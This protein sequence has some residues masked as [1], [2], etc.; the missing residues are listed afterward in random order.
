MR[1]WT[2]R[3]S[4]IGRREVKEQHSHLDFAIAV[5]L[6][7]EALIE[8]GFAARI[9]GP[10]IVGMMG[11]GGFTRFEDFAEILVRNE[12]YDG[13]FGVTP[14]QVAD[15]LS[16]GFE[17]DLGAFPDFELGHENIAVF[18]AEEDVGLRVRCRGIRLRKEWLPGIDWLGLAHPAGALCAAHLPPLRLVVEPYGG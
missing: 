1:F 9:G 14:R 18:V 12:E 17:A 16:Q 13:S 5:S 7:V 6:Y 2:L 8:P 11:D 10:E 4:P 15:E 3:E